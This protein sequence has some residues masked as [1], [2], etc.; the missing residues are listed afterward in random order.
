MIRES[1]TYTFQDK[2]GMTMLIEE[3]I[4]PSMCAE[5]DPNGAFSLGYRFFLILLED[6]S[7]TKMD[8]EEV[9]AFYKNMNCRKDRI[10]LYYIMKNCYEV[11]V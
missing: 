10:S 7:I 9:K 6:M 5:F 3:T 8:A 2:N 11:P 4:Y 1:Q